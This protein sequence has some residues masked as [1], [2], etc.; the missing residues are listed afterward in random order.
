MGVLNRMKNSPANPIFIVALFLIA[1]SRAIT[2]FANP[3]P[4][5][6]PDSGTYYTGHF[7]DFDLVS[8]TGQSARGWVVPV[9]YAFMPNTPAIAI[10]QLI[11]STMA[12]IYLL[13][14]ISRAYSSTKLVHNLLLLGIATLGSSPVIIQHDTSILA[15]SI[16]NTLFVSLIAVL[17]G[18]KYRKN[19]ANGPIFAGI[20]FSGLLM[21]QKTTFIP[22]VIGLV[23]LMFISANKATLPKW[24]N[25]LGFAFVIL[26]GFSLYVGNNVNSSWQVS[27][28]GQ[29]LLWQLGGQS[30][31]AS[32]FARYLQDI[33]APKCLTADA[34]YQNL[35]I[36]IG[37]ILSDCPAGKQYLKTDFQ[38]EFLR[39]ILTH[40]TATAKL[41]VT[42][43][44][45]AVTNS[46]SN[47]GSAV[48]ILPTFA[49]EMFFG[50][51]APNLLDSKVTS[52]VEGMNL[53]N[54]GGAYW[55]F[56]PLFGW[57]LFAG[58]GMILR[59]GSWKE[60]F[61]LYL[62]MIFCLVQ[63]A[64]IVILLPSE[65]VRQ[66]SP[67]IIGTLITALILSIK[68]FKGASDLVAKN[69]M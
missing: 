55:I 67:F 12:W 61:E 35:N 57:V 14:A 69:G 20:F 59:K 27:Y 21:I 43:I 37:R 45:A 2:F 31:A 63:S 41:A 66:T 6:S 11:L 32:S 8:L 26:T 17:V 39:F 53:L 9:V 24:R 29:T 34:P 19:S 25:F 38:K 22:I 51:T 4:Y 30:P 44:G 62:I 68:N 52:Q 46:S 18:L 50:T 7:L 13:K 64:F 40:P 15:T 16:T 47:Y 33:G 56:A 65:W 36:S 23:C 3:Y 42:G 54:T 28:S 1:G 58:L 48:S 49:S 5:T 60:D 10:T